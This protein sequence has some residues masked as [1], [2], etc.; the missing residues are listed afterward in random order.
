[1]TVQVVNHSNVPM[2][3][4]PSSRM[5]GMS[6]A[7]STMTVLGAAATIVLAI[8]GLAGVLPESMTAIA[9]IVLGATLLF[10]AGAAGTRHASFAQSPLAGESVGAHAPGRGGVSAETLG[11]LAGIALGILALL[12]FAPVILSTVALIAFGGALLIEN[13][14][15]GRAARAAARAGSFDASEVGSSGGE[16]LVGIGAAVLGI[17]ALLGLPN[18]SPITL[19][20]V[21]FLA[22]GSA[23]LLSGSSHG[24]RTL[25][26]SRHQHAAHHT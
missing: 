3:G 21:G 8:L 10:E 14:A 11:G 17:L 1:M 15:K 12:R 6:G 7:A 25:A 5:V 9:T 20:L 16:I 13:E 4:G 26:I 18:T 2:R 22:L 24:T 19:I 23:L